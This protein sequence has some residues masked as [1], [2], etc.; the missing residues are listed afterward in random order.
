[1]WIKI[2][3]IRDIDTANYVASLG[4]DAI[5]LNFYAPSPRSVSVEQAISI[6]QAV[7][8]R[9]TTVGLFVNHA[10]EE[11]RHISRQVGCDMLQFHGDE[12]PEFLAEFPDYRII[13]AFRLGEDGLVPIADYLRRCRALQAMPWA[14]LIDAAVT[15]H[16]GGSGVTLD[17]HKLAA[18]YHGGWPPMILAG[19]LTPAN[20]AQAIQV[21]QP[22]GVDVASGVESS[23][24]IK[25]HALIQEFVTQSR[26]VRV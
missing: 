21:A 14:C 17:W 7:R 15:G 11:V 16:Y 1:M 9:I 8:G 26:S 22:W 20:V 10:V 4:G 13:R 23:K 19:G 3:G 2:C 18:D 12:P 5:G 24:G 25:D 6:D